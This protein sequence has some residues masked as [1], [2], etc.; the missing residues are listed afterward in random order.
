MFYQQVE[1][2]PPV[3]YKEEDHISRRDSS[4]DVGEMETDPAA[5]MPEPSGFVPFKGEGNRLDGKKK[6]LVSESDSEPQPSNS[7]Q[8]RILY[9][10]KTYVSLKRVIM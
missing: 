10:S 9:S 8:V 1:F 5:M 7:R 2:A 4:G 6:K 3:G